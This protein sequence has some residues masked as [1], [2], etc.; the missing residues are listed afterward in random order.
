MT[1]GPA[2]ASVAAEGPKPE[3]AAGNLPKAHDPAAEGEAAAADAAAGP[4]EEQFSFS[5][6]ANELSMP[7]SH[8]R[9]GCDL[10][11]EL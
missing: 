7:R 6:A 4:H 11:G 2:Q 1:S 9:L 5:T 10:P 8:L 3:P